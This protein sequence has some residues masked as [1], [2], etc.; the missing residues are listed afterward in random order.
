M[1]MGNGRDDRNASRMGRG[2]LYYQPDHCMQAFKSG[3]RKSQVFF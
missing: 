3:M 1:Q 2:L